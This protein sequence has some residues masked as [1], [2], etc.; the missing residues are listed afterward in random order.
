MPSKIHVALF[1]YVM[2]MAT[3]AHPTPQLTN[4][5][6]KRVNVLSLLLSLN[7]VDN[8]HALVYLRRYNQFTLYLVPSG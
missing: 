6:P 5:T 8:P 4:L 2:V 7:Q 1:R 3:L